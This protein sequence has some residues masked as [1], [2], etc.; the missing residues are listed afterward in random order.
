VGQFENKGMLPGTA[1][2]YPAFLVDHWVEG[3][4]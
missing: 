4:Q 3:L 2:T 1:T